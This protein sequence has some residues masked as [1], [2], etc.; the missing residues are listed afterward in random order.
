MSDREPLD[1]LISVLTIRDLVRR[2]GVLAEQLGLKPGESVVNSLASGMLGGGN[3]I[4][5]MPFADDA[6]AQ[7]ARTSPARLTD[8]EAALARYYGALLKLDGTPYADRIHQ[9]VALKLA[10]GN[11]ILSR[12]VTL[13]TPS[14]ERF[15]GA[16][17]RNGNDP[18]NRMPDRATPLATGTPRYT[19]RY[20]GGDQGIS[21]QDRARRPF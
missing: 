20:G 7:V 11:D 15:V 6:D 21:A 12:L 1:Y 2:E 9:A 10:G 3:P 19:S 13:M 4:G 5:F 18:R 8:K 14:P 17:A 16:I